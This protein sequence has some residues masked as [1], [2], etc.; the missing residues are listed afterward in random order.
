MAY[1]LRNRRVFFSSPR[2][3]CIAQNLVPE[4][5]VH[6]HRIQEIAASSTPDEKIHQVSIK[7][8]SNLKNERWMKMYAALESFSALCAAA[9]PILPTNSNHPRHNGI[10]RRLVIRP[11]RYPGSYAACVMTSLRNC[12]GSHAPN[13]TR[14]SP[15]ST[16][17]PFQT[18]A[19]R[20]PDLQTHHVCVR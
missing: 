13:N 7:L 15:S 17:G 11:S 10:V 18:R 20:P 5:I 3:V 9:D 1:M 2:Y 14:R 12:E 4:L 6:L 19:S 8:V 16:S